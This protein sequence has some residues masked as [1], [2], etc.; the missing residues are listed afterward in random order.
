MG[1][2]CGSLD[3]P[4]PERHFGERKSRKNDPVRIYLQRRHGKCVDVRGLRHEHGHGVHFRQDELWGD[5]A[6][7]RKDQCGHPCVFGGFIAT[8]AE[9]DD[10]HHTVAR[11][12]EIILS[13]V[14]TRSGWP[15][16]D[17]QVSYPHERG[18]RN[19]YKINHCPAAAPGGN[20]LLRSAERQ[21]RLRY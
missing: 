5:E 8:E 21:H 19:A 15:I 11:N 9:V 7:A 3:R 20:E 4:K 1:S 2:I 12:T 6:I 10:L 18:P 13:Q 14:S 17:V 16:G